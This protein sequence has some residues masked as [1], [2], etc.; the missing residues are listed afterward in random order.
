VYLSGVLASIMPARIIN[1]STVSADLHSAMGFRAAQV[2][3]VAHGY[4]VGRFRPDPTEA[5]M[6]RETLGIDGQSFLIGTVSRW[7]AQKDIPN[8]ISALGRARD[9]LPGSWCCL[10]VGRGLDAANQE[11]GEQIARAEVENQVVLL[12]ERPDVDRL[13][14]SLDV[15]VLPSAEEAFPNVVAEAMA[16]EV[17][18]VVTKV[19]DAPAM[20]GETGWVV[21]A[22]EPEALAEALAN[23]RNEWATDRSS[24]TARQRGARHRVEANYSLD[25]MVAAYRD[26]WEQVI[27]ERR[28]GGIRPPQR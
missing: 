9:Q 15:L 1:C 18:C 27:T 19:G 5:R 26:V 11:L 10:L 25:R 12:G 6:V 2:R 14:R 22:K 21:P 24:W 16:T 28:S 7:H 8:L 4:D 20:V 13:M 23:A 17:P 3:V